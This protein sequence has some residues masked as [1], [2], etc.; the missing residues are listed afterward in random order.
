MTHLSETLSTVEEDLNTE[1]QTASQSS[2]ENN[3]EETGT[4]SIEEEVKP[5]VRRLSLF[6]TLDSSDSK[7]L[8]IQP[9][10]QEKSEPPVHTADRASM[11]TPSFSYF[12]PTGVVAV[13]VVGALESR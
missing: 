8:F 2:N 5:S 1:E 6:D 7:N 12:S 3:P 9:S 11:H 10:S 4:S 13:C